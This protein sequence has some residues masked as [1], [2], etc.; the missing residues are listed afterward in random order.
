[1]EK[2]SLPILEE[3]PQSVQDEA[4]ASKASTEVMKQISQ[5]SNDVGQSNSTVF[6][7][8]RTLNPS[9]TTAEESR[10]R[11]EPSRAQR[12]V[13]S[14]LPNLTAV[15]TGKKLAKKVSSLTLMKIELL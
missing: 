14:P 1:M 9:P 8:I 7:S 5:A 6:L 10:E 2:S 11:L 3:G 4:S 15:L 12:N 13:D